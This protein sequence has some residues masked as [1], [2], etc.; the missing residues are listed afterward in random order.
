[1][2][3]LVAGAAFVRFGG[4][5][6]GLLPARSLG[7]EWFDLDELEVS[8]VGRSSGRRVRLG[9][10]MSVRVH[11]VDRARGRVLLDLHGA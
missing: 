7:R 2:V 3:G 6:E 10:D 5:Y 11:S 1:V 4:V 8:L 9:D